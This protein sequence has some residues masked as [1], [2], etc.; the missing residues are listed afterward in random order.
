MKVFRI[1]LLALAVGMLLASIGHGNGPAP[2][3]ALAPGLRQPILDLLM[4]CIVVTGW[5]AAR[6]TGRYWKS[7]DPKHVYY[8]LDE[9]LEDNALGAATRPVTGVTTRLPDVEEGQH[10]TR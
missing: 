3:E 6:A 4:L 1:T 5:L 8:V 10:G 2:I 7:G 9:P